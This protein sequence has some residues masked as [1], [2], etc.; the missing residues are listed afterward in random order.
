M[1]TGRPSGS[2]D[3]VESAAAAFVQARWAGRALPGFPGTPPADLAGGYAIQDRAIGLWPDRVAGW[4]VGYISPDRRDGSGDD[5]VVGPIFAAEVWP[6]PPGGT[7][8]VPV[9]VGGF[10]AVEA[11]FVFRL[12]ADAPAD[13]VQ[14][15]ARD[16]L[17]LVAALH[18]GIETAGSPLATINVLGPTVV[19]SDFGNNA[20]LVLGPEIPGWREL[21]EAGLVCETFIEGV[22]VGR[23]GAASVP[24]GL[25]E[26]L[27]FALARCARRGHP[28]KAG[29]LVTT[30]A[31]T[32]IHD[33]LAGQQALIRFGAWGE[34]RCRAVAAT[35]RT[36][37]LPGSPP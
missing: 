6:Q 9:F 14:W 32:G 24:G 12:A 36:P 15:S 37:S 21:P 10:A 17:A 4:K 13:R 30:G 31:A 19:V 8:D 3:A 22:S 25:G 20:G 18:I 33:I 29:D 11:E 35:A 1:T 23:G 2:A 28:L 26:A 34:L 27:A 5:R 7:R 16:A